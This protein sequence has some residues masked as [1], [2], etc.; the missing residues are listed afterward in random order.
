[1]CDGLPV[2]RANYS[3]NSKLTSGAERIDFTDEENPTLKLQFQ[4]RENNTEPEEDEAC[5][6]EN[7]SE[8]EEKEVYI[9]A[10]ADDSLA[11]ADGRLSQ[12]DIL[13][14]VN[15]IYRIGMRK[16]LKYYTH[17]GDEHKLTKQT[18]FILDKRNRCSKSLSSGDIIR[19]S[20]TWNNFACI[21]AT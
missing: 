6:D 4:S 19:R 2:D 9:Q 21:S 12:G 20:W 13:L 16:L 10:I 1:M 3:V 18:L 11:A 8:N 7:D 17:S 14:Q 5:V 15:A